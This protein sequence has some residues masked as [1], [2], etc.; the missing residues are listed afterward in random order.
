MT[1]MVMLEWFIEDFVKQEGFIITTRKSFKISVFSDYHASRSISKFTL[2]ARTEPLNLSE[3]STKASIFVQ[4]V[5]Q[6]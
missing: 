1:N 4:I 2:P 3:L 6:S 5:L